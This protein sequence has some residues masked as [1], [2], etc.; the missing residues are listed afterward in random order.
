MTSQYDKYFS[1]RSAGSAITKLMY[2]IK[3]RLLYG[4]DLCALI[5]DLE[6]KDLLEDKP[7]EDVK[8]P[9]SQWTNE[10][11]RYLAGGYVSGYFSREY[12][13]YC[14][15]VAEYLHKKRGAVY[16]RIGTRGR[17]SKSKLV[18]LGIAGVVAVCLI[19]AFCSS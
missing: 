15:E 2:D 6:R 4:A 16:P 11:A 3:D 7:F 5:D 17:S 10:Y 8:K 14:A 12:L 13:L 19:I 1:G 9:Q 18:P